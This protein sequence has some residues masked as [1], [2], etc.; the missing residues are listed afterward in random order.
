MAT[1]AR[2]GLKISSSKMIS[3]YLHWAGSPG[4]VGIKLLKY[5]NSEQKVKELITMGNASIIGNTI[6][7]KVNFDNFKVNE[8][9]QCLFYA[10]DR[11]EI[12]QEAETHEI[13]DNRYNYEFSYMFKCGAWYV[14]INK[15]YVLLTEKICNRY[16]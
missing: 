3:I 2:I 15:N 9:S 4:S 11:G 7:S 14:R 12:N 1:N 8:N 6:G 16:F 5:F 10:R 13:G